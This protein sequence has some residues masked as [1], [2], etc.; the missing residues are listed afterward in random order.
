LFVY[1]EPTSPKVLDLRRDARYALHCGVEDH[2]GGQGEFLVRGRAFE[3]P[4]NTI[5]EEAFERARATGRHPLE[6]YILFELRVAEASAT[7]YED[8]RPK[9]TKWKSG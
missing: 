1:M 5:R 2:D 7:L 6:R 4:D 8:D 9:R 3:I